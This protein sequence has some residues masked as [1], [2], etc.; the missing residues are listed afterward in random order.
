MKKLTLVLLSFLVCQSAFA[1]RVKYN[2]VTGE[3]ISMAYTK[4]NKVGPNEAILDVNDEVKADIQNYKVDS[5][6]LFRVKTPLEVAQDQ[7]VKDLAKA[8]RK[9][10]KKNIMTKLGLNKQELKALLELIQDGSDD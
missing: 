3:V 8:D 9:A 5:D 1:A 6:G 10:R 7:A 2:S 4:D